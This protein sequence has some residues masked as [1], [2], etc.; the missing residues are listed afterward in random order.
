MQDQVY[1][2]GNPGVGRYRVCAN[3]LLGIGMNA[4]RTYDLLQEACRALEAAGDHAI[5]AYVGVSMAM[6]QEKYRVGRDHLDPI[7]QD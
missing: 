7:D 3:G 2:C 6:V 5:S 4:A 1:T